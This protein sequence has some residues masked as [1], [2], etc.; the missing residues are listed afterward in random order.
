MTAE[1]SSQT[2]GHEPPL[3][4]VVLGSRG[5]E[6]ARAQ[7]KLV[8]DAL[9]SA[10]P[11][12]TVETRIIST[13]GDEANA[14]RSRPIDPRAGRKGLFTAEIE[15]VLA[16]GEIDLAVHSAK[17]LPSAETAGLEIRGVLERGDV[18]DVL[19]RK[20]RGAFGSLGPGSRVA[21]GSVRRQH[22]LRWRYPGVDIVELRGNVPTRLRKLLSNNWDGVVLARAG[23]ERLGHRLSGRS[24]EFE[25]VELE[26]EVLS[27]EVFVPAGGQGV[28]A[29]QVRA[30][31]EKTTAAVDSVS[32]AATLVCLQAEREFLRL[33]QGDCDSPVGVLATIDEDRLK[34]RAQVFEAGKTEPRTGTVE[35]PI[36]D[37]ARLADH[38]LRS[39]HGKENAE[40]E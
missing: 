34:L 27:P 20:S 8:E 18:N 32:N 5:S 33:L 6:L 19:I 37:S 9:R 29:M 1:L 24:F 4:K 40:H 14:P 7:A 11:G 22:Q 23:V 26:A 2:G 35:G 10:W 30:N 3:R 16:A 38:L 25:G 28:I 39:I 31:D 17:D 13:R 21:T 12:L 36:K 15:R